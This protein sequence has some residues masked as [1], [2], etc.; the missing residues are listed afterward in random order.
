MSR[1]KRQP[2]K[3]KPK[4]RPGKGFPG[5]QHQT[6]GWTP[7]PKEKGPDNTVRMMKILDKYTYTYSII[8]EIENGNRFVFYSDMENYDEFK[9]KLLSKLKD[10]HVSEKEDRFSLSFQI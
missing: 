6:E 5:P 10:V 4:K 3:T 8:M 2:Q 1:K 7:K 9:D